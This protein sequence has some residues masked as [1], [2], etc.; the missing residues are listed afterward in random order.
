MAELNDIQLK[1]QIA[2]GR[3]R[4]REETDQVRVFLILGVRKLI[5]PVHKIF[6]D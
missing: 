1:L 5:V 2:E 6:D 4:E 3:M